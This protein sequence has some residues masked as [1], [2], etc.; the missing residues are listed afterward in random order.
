MKRFR[1]REGAHLRG[2]GRRGHV[3]AV[4]GEV[5]GHGLAQVRLV[6]DDCYARSQGYLASA[7]GGK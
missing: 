3:E 1:R 7:V 6:F 4:R 5:L 2:I